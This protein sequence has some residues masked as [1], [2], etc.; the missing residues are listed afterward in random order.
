MD[1]PTDDATLAAVEHALGGSL[2]MDPEHG[3]SLDAPV[4]VGAD[5]GLADLLDF[6][7][8]TTQPDPE[9]CY[10]IDGDGERMTAEQIAR[11]DAMGVDQVWLD[12]RPHYSEHD[13]IA[14]L[15]VEVRRLRALV[16]EA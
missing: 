11:D 3:G 12:E 4:R 2:S 1:F 8:G 6:L 16:G 13:V 10:R 15:I 9:R 7:A 5:Y 14:A